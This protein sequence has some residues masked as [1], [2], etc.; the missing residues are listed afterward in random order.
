MGHFLQNSEAMGNAA[1]FSNNTDQ[2][3]YDAAFHREGP[4]LAAFLHVHDFFEFVVYLGQEPIQYRV[5]DREYRAEFG[6]ILVCDM[7]DEHMLLC[8]SNEHHMRFSV[9]LSFSFV[10]ACST[11]D[12][13]LLQIFSRN[14]NCYPVLH[15]GPLAIHKYVE[16]IHQFEACPL[17]HGKT[18]FQQAILHQI[19]AY[20]QDDFLRVNGAG[21]TIT[22]QDTLVC[23]LVN[24]I[25]LHIGEDLS[26][27]ALGRITNYNPTYLSRTFKNMTHSPLKVYIDEKRIS[28]A[29][30]L[31]ARA[32]PLA[33]IAAQV[34]FQNYSTFYNTFKRLAGRSPENYAQEVRRLGGG[35]ESAV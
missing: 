32:L 12:D 13:N 4:N 30:L 7:L 16:L 18:V 19:L 15:V 8:D 22:R 2:Y 14:S 28:T 20:L 3:G 25:N 6:D 21:T 29:K 33:E 23:E 24:Y 1:R 11:K 5:A 34:G 35:Q 10:M 9:G 27:K 31:M 26:L 17:Q